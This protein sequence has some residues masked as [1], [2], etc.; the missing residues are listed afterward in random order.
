MSA[1]LNATTS[2]S[3][4]I[5]TI[6]KSTFDNNVT[7]LFAFAL[8]IWGIMFVEYWKRENVRLAYEWDVEKFE[9][10]E[11]DLPEYKR[12][13]AEMKDYLSRKGKIGKFLFINIDPIKRFISFLIILFLVCFTKITIFIY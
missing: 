5:D 1:S 9:Q 10:Y 12:R 4:A 8:C 7:P 2:T 11:P 6:F 3:D 13:Q